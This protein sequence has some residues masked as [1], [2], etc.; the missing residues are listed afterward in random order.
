[1]ADNGAGW[2]KLFRSLAGHSLWLTDPFSIGQAWVDLLMLAN[3]HD[4]TSFRG[5]VT[6]K[7]GQV[8]TS[9]YSLGTRWKRD[10]KTVRRWLLVFER[11]GMLARASAHGRDGGYTL[12]TLLNYETYQAR[13][14]EGLDDGRGDGRDHGRDDGRADAGDD[15]RDDGRE[16][17]KKFEERKEG[18]HASE[19]SWEGVRAGVVMLPFDG[20]NREW[21]RE[22]GGEVKP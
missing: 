4:S 2:I 22:P 19:S 1:V 7:R 5:D 21:S 9:I 6:V 3:Y 10:P 8:L 12:I 18:G 13:P 11:A 16:T 15:G 17:S 14:G 20:L